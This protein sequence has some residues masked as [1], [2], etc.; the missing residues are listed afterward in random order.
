MR[1]LAGRADLGLSRLIEAR[2]AR[3][4][5]LAI[6][7]GVTGAIAS[8]AA[9]VAG[10]IGLFLAGLNAIPVQGP[11]PVSEPELDEEFVLRDLV[12]RQ[13]HLALQAVGG[14]D[15]DEEARRLRHLGHEL[16][17]RYVP[18][19][20]RD[21]AEEERGWGTPLTDQEATTA[22]ERYKRRWLWLQRNWERFGW[23]TFTERKVF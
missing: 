16:L 13:A 14:R 10:A 20:E 11:V 12:E 21:L 7:L 8:A 1:R 22:I 19:V 4:T 3:A 15:E 2:N 23:G 18:R 5:D 9:M 17:T 6:E